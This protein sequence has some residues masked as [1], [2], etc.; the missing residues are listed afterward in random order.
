VLRIA[1]SGADVAQ[2]D[3]AAALSAPRTPIEPGR[4][5][6]TAD[7]TAVFAMG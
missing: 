4:T 7:L 6:V 2:Y 3:T 1:E 5:R